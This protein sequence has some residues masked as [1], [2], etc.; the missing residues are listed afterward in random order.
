M[1]YDYRNAAPEPA[2]EVLTAGG[3][4]PLTVVGAYGFLRLD[5]GQWVTGSQDLDR[6]ITAGTARK[7]SPN[8]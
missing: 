8:R 5:V 4:V 3:W 1:L 6:R 7:T 2:H